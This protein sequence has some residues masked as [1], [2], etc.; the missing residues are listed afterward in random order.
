M[1]WSFSDDLVAWSDWTPN[2]NAV[3]EVPEAFRYKR[4]WRCTATASNISDFKNFTAVS[5]SDTNLHFSAPPPPG[6]VITAD[7]TTKTVAKDSNHV[8]DLTVTIQLGEYMG[9]G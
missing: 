4:Y 7:Y 5:G 3:V 1:R 9:G 6:A 8:F 2:S